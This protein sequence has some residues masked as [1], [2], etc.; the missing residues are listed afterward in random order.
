MRLI[1]SLSTVIVLLFQACG[2]KPPD[3]ASIASKAA[4]G[5]GSGYEGMNGIVYSTE[6]TCAD[7]QPASVLKYYNNQYWI[8]RW[9]CQLVS[10]PT[11]IDSSQIGINVSNVGELS[12]GGIIFHRR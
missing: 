10:P 11:L 7:G 12:Y 5:N 1:L 6:A 4:P 3:N 9:D 8:E 2:T